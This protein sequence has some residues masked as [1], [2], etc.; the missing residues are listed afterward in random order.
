MPTY[1]ITDSVFP[2]CSSPWISSSA[3]SPAGVLAVFE[4]VAVL[5][6]AVWLELTTTAVFD[7]LA[8]FAVELFAVVFAALPQAEKSSA[9]EAMLN[10]E[11]VVIFMT[12]I[13]PFLKADLS[14]SVRVLKEVGLSDMEILPLHVNRLTQ[15]GRC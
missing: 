8:V 7:L 3:D 2:T 1:K 15:E 11:K 4:T 5:F 6:T 12:F 13:F 10:V 14:I 9:K